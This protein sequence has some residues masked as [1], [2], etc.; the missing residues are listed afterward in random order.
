VAESEK[1]FQPAH[2]G[3]RFS[4]PWDAGIRCTDGVD[5]RDGGGMCRRRAGSGGLL[6]YFAFVLSILVRISAFRVSLD[7]WTRRKGGGIGSAG[8]SRARS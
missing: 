8:S 1:A 3:A 5:A 2:A 6:E 7:P 4:Q